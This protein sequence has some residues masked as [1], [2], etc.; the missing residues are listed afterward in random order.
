MKVTLLGTGTSSGVPMIACDCPTCTSDDPRDNRTRC[1]AL[2]ETIDRDGQHRAILIDAGPDLHFQA[3]RHHLWRCDAILL[4]H[5][6]VDHIFGLDETRRFNVAQGAPIDVYADQHTI[7]SV[8]RIFQHIFEPHLSVNHSFVASLVPHVIT[9]TDSLDLFGIRIT[10]IP[11]MHGKLPIFGFRIEDT[12]PDSYA[13]PIAYCT[14]VSHIPPKSSPLL[15][16]L[17]VL[18]LDALRPHPH[19]TH[20]T[21]DDA[22]D[23]AQRIAA[24][25]TY[26]IHMAHS[27]KHADVDPTLPPGINLAYDTLTLGDTLKLDGTH[28]TR[29]E[30]VNDDPAS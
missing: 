4:T 13:G 6:H 14:D 15:A 12:N 11:L 30:A 19:P 20:L 10:P 3:I 28:I 16:D 24:R 29:R 1:S 17:D 18:I 27:I 25:Q 22:I 26:F 5:N 9:E 21:L 8:K 7:D 2:I 23:E